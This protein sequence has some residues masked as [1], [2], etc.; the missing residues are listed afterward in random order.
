MHVLFVHQNYPAQFG[1]LARRLVSDFGWEC[2]CVSLF[3]PPGMDSGVRCIQYEVKGG[4]T[5]ETHYCS[6]TFENIVWNAHAVAETCEREIKS[7]P[8]LIVGHSGLASTLF[9]RE[10]FDCPIINYFE[11][12]YRVYESDA[13]F[14]HEFQ[15]E[16]IDL[17]R[18]RARNAMLLLDL[19]NCDA[20]YS[21]TRW[22]RSR[23]P[24]EFLPKIEVIFDGIE[25][26]FWRRKKDLPRRVGR[27]RLKPG[28]RIITYASP[29]LEY[30]RGFDIFMQTARCIYEAF[31][32]VV[33]IVAGA[34]RTRY[35]PDER[36]TGGRSFK[37]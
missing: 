26:D 4:A 30:T 6:R 10:L 13:D 15:P 27:R 1:H 34:E 35:G 17:M 29:G 18:A 20:G 36:M 22:Q 19:E 5:E 3:Q 37:E 9:L 11:Y 14:R 25:T 32:D 16:R 23:F 28:T 21:P 24:K 8:D 12:F 33:F 31:P 2:T 7:A